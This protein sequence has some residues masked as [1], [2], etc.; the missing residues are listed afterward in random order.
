M[1]ALMLALPLVGAAADT[2]TTPVASQ[3][4]NDFAKGKKALENKNWKAAI[5]AFARAVKTEPRNADFHNYLGYAYRHTD[6]ME[7]SFQ[8]YNEALKLDPNHRG[9]HEYIGWAYLQTD[10]LG[11]AEGHLAQL[12]KIC[13]KTCEEYVDLHNGVVA[14][15]A[16]K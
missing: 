12:E 5:D 8:H 2:D 1:V 3:R 9:A 16:K 14:Y 10:R 6:K 13:G 4:N 11:K 15:K 7:L